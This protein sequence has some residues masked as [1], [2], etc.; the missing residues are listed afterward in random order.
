[1]IVLI[2]CVGC[3]GSLLPIGVPGSR[4]YASQGGLRD[5][6]E[7]ASGS[8]LGDP[9]IFRSRITTVEYRGAV[10]PQRRLPSLRGAPWRGPGKKDPAPSPHGN[11]FLM[12][13]S[14]RIR[15]FH[16]SGP[17][18]RCGAFVVAPAF[19]AL[20]LG[21]YFP[22]RT[23]AMFPSARSQS[24]SAVHPREFS[25]RSPGERETMLKNSA[26]SKIFPSAVGAYQGS[27]GPPAL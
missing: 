16:S 4:R 13:S 6:R 10:A 12:L 23:L 26:P 8:V 22:S 20:A 19:T 27:H 3:Q 7:E 15:F 17:S 18:Y 2:C 5:P 21:R 11:A 1:M 9:G 14:A 24:R 25:P